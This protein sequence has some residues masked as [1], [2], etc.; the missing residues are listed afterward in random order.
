MYKIAQAYALL[1]EKNSAV[2]MLERSVN[3]GFVCYPY[4]KDDPLLANI[5]GDPRY[6]QILES[7]R[8]SHQEFT[9]AFA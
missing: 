6:I 4:L 7:A 5:Q 9:R 1:N 8:K 2:R 3:G